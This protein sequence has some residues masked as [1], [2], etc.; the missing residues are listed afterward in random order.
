M[1]FVRK[2]TV[3][4]CP[5]IR[6]ATHGSGIQLAEQRWDVDRLRSHEMVVR[7]YE[8]GRTFDCDP[9]P[10]RSKDDRDLRPRSQVREFPG[11]AAR[12]EPDGRL[13]GHGMIENPGVYH[14]RLERPV[15]S[16]CNNNSQSTFACTEPSCSDKKR[17]I[18]AHTS[19][20]PPAGER[21]SAQPMMPT[22][23]ID[24]KGC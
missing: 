2:S 22:M 6:H 8:L 23:S 1:T 12:D 19:C 16:A 10:T 5:V 18:P 17:M 7:A 9:L 14:G 13:A 15:N 11:V 21:K 3:Q 4:L 24:A 20:S